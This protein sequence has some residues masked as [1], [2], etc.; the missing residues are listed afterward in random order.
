[1]PPGLTWAYDGAD[2]GDLVTA[3]ATGG[4]PHP[5]GYPTFLMAASVFLRLPIGSLAYRTNLLSAVCTV[6]AALVVYLLVQTLKHDTF[7]SVVA[8]LA[9]GT[10]P[11]VWSQA[12]IT[13]V[14]ALNGLFAALLLY[15]AARGDS[16]PDW[17]I[18]GGVIG[19]LALGNHLSIIF[20]LPLLFLP[21]RHS[22]D[23]TQQAETTWR[24]PGRITTLAWR[25]LGLLLGLA[26]YVAIP[27]RARAEAPVNWGN[28]VDLDGFAWLVSGRA[29]W[30]RLG[31]LDPGYLWTGAQAWS[32]ILFRQLGI[33]G[34]V[35][36]ATVL[37]TT[38]RRSWIHL[39]CAWMVCAYSAFAVLFYSPDSYVYL[40]PALMA[41]S[42]WMASGARWI[43]DQLGSHLPRLRAA[44]PALILAYLVASGIVAIPSIS[45]SSDRG[46]EQYAHDALSSAPAQAI[47][48]T[49]G[50][51][52]TF[53]LWYLHY[54][55]HERPDVAVISGDLLFQAWY[56]KELA[57][58]YPDLHIATN[59]LQPDIVADNPTRPACTLGPSLQSTLDC[60][61]G[62]QGRGWQPSRQSQT[63]GPRQ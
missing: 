57:D 50:D 7:M 47:I 34:F 9:F 4:V 59:A 6:L 2:G 33:V 45:L 17:V 22:P 35:L 12:I 31:D 24:A 44:A 27:L 52:T 48:F 1:M 20:M 60:S 53:S 25:T 18:A 51:E 30:G 32:H 54:A 23:A 36:V 29:Y 37:A 16:T 46:A 8:S 42:I 15:W 21:N 28:A 13:E 38:F 5:T 61:S 62:P 63:A 56:R 39:A 41:L 26:V 58:T 43:V 55:Y 14:Y 11:L 40:I 49:R 19:G 10:L 3:A